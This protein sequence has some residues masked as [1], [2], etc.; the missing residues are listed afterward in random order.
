VAYAFLAMASSFYSKIPLLSLYKG[1]EVGAY[2]V[3]GLYIGTILHTWR[4]IEDIVDIML[5]GMW[6]LV[7]SALI[8]AVIAPSMAW[9][10]MESSE[11][12]AFGLLGVF[13][14]IN[15]N[16]LTQLS[17][18]I[19]CCCICRL[20]CVPKGREKTGVMVVFIVAVICMVLAHSRTSI[21]AF[22]IA[23]GLVFVSFRKKGLALL[24]V[25]LG[26]LIAAFAALSEYLVS[27]LMRGNTMGTFTSLGGR[28]HFWP[29]VFEQFMRSPIIGHG[30]YASQRFLFGTSTV[31]NTYLEVLLGLGLIGIMV[32]CLAILGVFINVWRSRPKASLREQGLGNQFIWTELAVIFLFLFVRTFTG[33]SFQVLH[34]D[35][36]FFVLVT[37]CASAAYRLK[38]E[39]PL[40]QMEAKAASGESIADEG[41]LIGQPATAQGGQLESA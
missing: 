33:P 25:S 24:A 40:R 14:L 38:K 30:F 9:A 10:K 22:L 5:F 13:P 15:S 8:G 16:T 36:T 29:M 18:T 6:Y 3:L 4:D 12:M 26:G 20:F 39:A 41:S 34:V 27:Y 32:F 37:V 35:L 19:A 23:M 7:I 31:D 2:V 21:F 1:F 28:T 17:G 11:S